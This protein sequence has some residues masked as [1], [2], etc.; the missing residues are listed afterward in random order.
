[1]T[2]QISRRTVT[3]GAAWTAPM[4]TVAVAAPTF[5]ASVPP[6]QIEGNSTGGKCP[7]QSTSYDF[8]FIVPLTITGSGADTLTITNVV[9]NG[10]I[11]GP[12]DFC[13]A[14]VDDNHYVIAFASTS[15]ANGV[16]GGTFD[17]TIVANGQTYNYTA[18]TFSYDGTNP[19]PNDRRQTDCAAAGLC[20][21]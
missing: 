17:Y 10:Q 6:P 12:D 4:V 14:K 18:A 19:V 16:G 8:G 21:D 3:K 7:G 1:M 5:A 9:Y 13:V 15:S 11:L 2:K 20:V